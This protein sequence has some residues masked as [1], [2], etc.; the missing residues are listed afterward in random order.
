MGDG[1]ECVLAPLA[2]LCISDAKNGQENRLSRTGKGL[3]G[4]IDSRPGFSG[5]LGSL[6]RG[7][8][9]MSS[10]RFRPARA[11]ACYGRADSRLYS[12]RKRADA[13]RKL[14]I[15]KGA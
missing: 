3:F 11:A 15:A 5:E 14:G 10:Y 9:R 4:G 6:Y 13:L 1:F 12:L 8:S 7:F 2:G